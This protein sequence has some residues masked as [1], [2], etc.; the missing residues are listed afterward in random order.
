VSLLDAR[1]GALY[2]L[3]DSRY[4]QDRTFGGEAGRWFAADD[5]VLS[6]FLAGGEE[7]PPDLLPRARHLLGVPILFENNPRGLLAAGAQE[8]RRGVGPFLPGARRTLGLFA[9]QAAIALENARL[10]L[11][12]LEQERLEREMHVAAE[13][14]R[15]ILP[16]GAPQV[17]GFELTG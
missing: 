3:E 14:Q 11:R 4:R 16:K 10:H 12:A 13:I 17:P 2:I 15:R 9:N 7:G 6:A 8:S 5:P 1:R